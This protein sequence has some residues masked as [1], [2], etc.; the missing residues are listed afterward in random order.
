VT[1]ALG[2]T[3]LVNVTVMAKILVTVLVT[4]ANLVDV[5]V[6]VAAV[7][8]FT[9]TV[10]PLGTVTIGVTVDVKSV[11]T[12]NVRV[13]VLVTVVVVSVTGVGSVRVIT[14]LSG[15]RFTFAARRAARFSWKLRLLYGMERPLKRK[16]ASTGAGAA[17][18]L[19]RAEA[20]M[21]ARVGFITAVLSCVRL[22]G[23][24]QDGMT[25]IVLLITVALGID[26]LIVKVFV[27][28]TVTREGVM[29]RVGFSVCS[30]ILVCPFIDI[31]GRSI[32]TEG[33]VVVVVGKLDKIVFVIVT[34]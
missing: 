23:T 16:C 31:G 12:W 15:A 14:L 19:A 34:T 29:V 17:E 20:V 32:T 1:L 10:S 3:V 9:M 18:R 33:T 6:G 8:V 28:V 7:T 25:I 26:F 27:V 21:P 4:T 13:E 11:D 24:V 5:L 2:N 22:S 30:S